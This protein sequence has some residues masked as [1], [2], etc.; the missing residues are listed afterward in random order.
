MSFDG[1]ALRLLSDHADKVSDKDAVRIAQALAAEDG[2][3]FAKFIRTR[4]EADPGCADKP[5]PL[6]LDYIRTI[7]SELDQHQRV[8]LAKSRQ[9]L[10]SWTV[11]AYATWWARSK[12][13]QAIYWQTK[14]WEDAVGM[15]SMPEGGFEGR[16]QFI[17]SHLPAWLRVPHKPSE[18]RIQYANGSI[19]QALAGGAD[20]IRS[21]VASVI[22][23]DEFAFQDDQEGVYTAVN[24]LVQKGAKLIIMST[25]NGSD[26]TFSTL[27]HGYRVGASEAMEA[28]RA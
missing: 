22:V 7:W 13:N 10:M 19:I 26:N 1:S 18:G 6:H 27:Y 12:P 16:C 11:T 4:D 25:P 5:F 17:E 24:P 3:F 20:K 28:M 15:V 2:L 14:A 21:K 9:M 23:E 8:I